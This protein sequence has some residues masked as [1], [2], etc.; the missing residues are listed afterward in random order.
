L[1]IDIREV[2]MLKIL[3]E[4]ATSWLLKGILI[5][6]AVTFISWGGSTLLRD[7]TLTY[8]AKVNGT[9]I[10]L[11]EYSEAYQ[12]LIKQYRDTLGPSFN[13][14]MVTEL[15]LR[16]KLLDDFINRILLA[17][18][19]RKLGLTVNDDELREMIQSVPAFQAEGRFD[20]RRYEYFLRQ[21]RMS[22][23]DFERTQREQIQISRVVNLVRQN[24][25]KVSAQA[26]W[27]TFLFENERINLNFI[28]ISPDA[29]RSQVT[30]N[31]IEIKDYYSK[32]QEEFRTPTFVQI[33]YLAFRPS[34][35]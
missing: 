32:N 28:K 8:A 31:D 3:R 11:R 27:D 12:N 20:P 7:K 35:F 21:R 10:D 5:L 19:A 34:D 15:K 26:V 33:Q 13:E 2:F 22:A 4:H 23:E 29:F 30:V 6:V 9:V 17:E 24:I 25:A 1:E 16:E 14:K 18:E